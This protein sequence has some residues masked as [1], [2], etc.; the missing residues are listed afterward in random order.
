MKRVRRDQRER[1]K[2]RQLEELARLESV[3]AELEIREK[4]ARENMQVRLL[5]RQAAARR[6]KV[7]AI[8]HTATHCN[9]LQHT[10]THCNTLQHTATHCNILQHTATQRR[11][12][13]QGVGTST[14]IEMRC[15]SLQRTAAHYSALQRPATH[16][17]SRQR[18]AVSRR[19]VLALQ[20]VM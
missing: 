11:A 20:H 7:L 18:T 13:T 3:R 9:T 5:E 4:I 12:S 1:I 6:R 14:H 19:N 10:A 15:D 2:R 16:S 17:S 8:Q